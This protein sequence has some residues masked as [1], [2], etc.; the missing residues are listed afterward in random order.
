MRGVG[1]VLPKPTESYLALLRSYPVWDYSRN[2]SAAL[3]RLG[4]RRASLVPIGY[5]PELTRICPLEENIDV[6]FYGAV[7]E[8]RGRAL[9]RM[10]DRGLRTVVAFGAY[11]AERD[12]LI[13]RSRIVVNIHYYESRVSR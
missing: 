2:N 12:A 9:Q 1:A 6:L 5:A 7:N 3:Y 10:K 4:V 11:G 13:A 8:R